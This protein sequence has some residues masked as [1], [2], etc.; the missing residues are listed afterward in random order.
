MTPFAND[1]IKVILLRKA[2]RDKAEV[3]LGEEWVSRNYPVFQ[4]WKATG[5]R[6]NHS[7]SGKILDEL[8]NGDV[9]DIDLKPRY[10]QKNGGWNIKL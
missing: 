10:Q 4:T 2:N 8:L 7:F 9:F 1:Y 5:E 3:K 6:C